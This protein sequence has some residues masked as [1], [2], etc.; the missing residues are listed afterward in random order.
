MFAKVSPTLSATHT[1]TCTA[2]GAATFMNMFVL[3]VS[4]NT[5][6]PIDVTNHF[7]ANPAPRTSMQP[8]SIT[9]SLS[10]ELIVTGMAMTNSTDTTAAITGGFHA[11]TIPQSTGNSYFGGMAYFVQPS[12]GA[13]NP[14]WSW[15]TGAGVG[16]STVIASFKGTFPSPPSGLLLPRPGLLMAGALAYGA[17]RL[18]D[19]P[20][21]SRR[22]FIRGWRTDS[23]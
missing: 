19:N 11:I 23:D 16:G 12:A 14:T 6:T 8:G 7:Y 5:G 1:F 9:P 4:G 20:Q 21:L 17:K 22:G 2:S 13:I 15:T 18:I 10:G 3:A